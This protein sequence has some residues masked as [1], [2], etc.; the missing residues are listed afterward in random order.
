MVCSSGLIFDP[1]EHNKA[2]RKADIIASNNKR[3][4]VMVAFPRRLAMT[5]VC[6]PNRGIVSS[7]SG[8]TRDLAATI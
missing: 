6:S 2:M 1:G 3:D 4:S 5:A 8:G 7:F